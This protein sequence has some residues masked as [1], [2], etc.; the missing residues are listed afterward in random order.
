MVGEDASCFK[1]EEGK[2]F[3]DNAGQGIATGGG[4]AL[5]FLEVFSQG[6]DGIVGGP[7]G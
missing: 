7:S 6:F 2:V 4:D 1:H 3:D 5:G